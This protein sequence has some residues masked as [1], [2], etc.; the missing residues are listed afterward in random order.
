MD[1][2]AATRAAIDRALSGDATAIGAL[3]DRLTPI[4]QAR[5]ARALTR[6]HAEARGRRIRQ[7]VEDMTQEVFLALFDQDGRALRAWDPDRGASLENFVGLVAERQV[8]SILRSGRRSPW[9][10][11]PTTKDELV[12]VV[13]EEDGGPSSPEHAAADRELL[14]AM[15][16]ALRVRLSPLGLEMF[17]HLFVEQADVPEICARTGLQAG[18]VYAWR[19][20]LRKIAQTI[21][22]DLGAEVGG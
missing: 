19:T 8:A 22:E 9:V 6:R 7:E 13:V 2:G 4:V 21:A 12:A 5:V 3:V 16:D 15:L 11:D 1:D 10:E 17:R 14:A 20:R 18:A